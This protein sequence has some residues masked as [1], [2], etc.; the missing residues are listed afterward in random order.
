M[1]GFQSIL[2]CKLLK[3]RNLH[4]RPA[5]RRETAINVRILRAEMTLK[6]EE[7]IK[8]ES[9][10]TKKK[11]E[12]PRLRRSLFLGFEEKAVMPANAGGAG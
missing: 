2:L 10:K 11:K 12:N 5:K 1:P 6:N 8:K 4:A 3:A 9:R 7:R